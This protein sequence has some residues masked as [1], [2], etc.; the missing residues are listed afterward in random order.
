[1]SSSRDNAKYAN[2]ET[3]DINAVVDKKSFTP[4]GSRHRSRH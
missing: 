4:D 1:M 2:N 3:T